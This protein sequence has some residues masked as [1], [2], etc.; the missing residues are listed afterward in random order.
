M[1]VKERICDLKE[2]KQHECETETLLNYKQNEERKTTYDNERSNP[3]LS[4]WGQESVPAT[5]HKLNG[6]G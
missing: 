4:Q 5:Q 3:N 6:K 1:C 2:K